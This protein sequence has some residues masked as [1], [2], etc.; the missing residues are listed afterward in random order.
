M[1]LLFF[2]KLE[3]IN[4]AGATKDRTTLFKDE[5]FVIDEATGERLAKWLNEGKA[6]E[7][8]EAEMR[9]QIIK[10][11]QRLGVEFD[12]KDKVKNNELAAGAIIKLTEMSLTETNTAA[13][14]ANLKKIKKPKVVA[15]SPKEHAKV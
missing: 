13:I 10:E 9:K 12:P 3:K 2:M 7:M 4:P 14:L 5:V 8:T 15:N 6:P 1:C 11:L